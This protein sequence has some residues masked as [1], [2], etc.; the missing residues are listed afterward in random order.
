MERAVVVIMSERTL[1]RS[2]QT[3]IEIALPAEFRRSLG[4]RVQSVLLPLLVSVIFLA[5]VFWNHANPDP[6]F[7]VAVYDRYLPGM[8]VLLLLLAVLGFFFSAVFVTRRRLFVMT[9][10]GF[11]LGVGGF[12]VR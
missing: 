11:R 5:A 2:R 9:G 7:S 1:S 6:D 4:R 8:L 10:V 3:P 12:G